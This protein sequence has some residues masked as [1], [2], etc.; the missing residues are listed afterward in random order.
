MRVLIVEDEKRI[1]D[2]LK[3]SLEAEYFAVD[4]VDDGDKGAYYAQINDYDLIILDIMLPKKDGFEVLHEL[5]SVGI[6]I[7][8]LVLSVKSETV[9][10]VDFLNAGADDYLTKPFVLSEL[11]A[12][13]R[14]LLRR[15]QKT[16]AE[17]FAV[18]DLTLN[19]KAGKVTRGKRDIYLTRKE[20]MLLRYLMQ[21]EG[22]IISRGMI[23][24]HVWDM[25]AD[26]F[27]NTI[28][29]H[30]LSLRKKLGDTGKTRLIQTVPGRGYKIEAPLT[31]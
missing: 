15:P 25:S 5:R 16:E 11:L 19:V 31:S 29:S 1:A 20:F 24:E 22:S 14:A 26:I 13:I 21:N 27:S 7:P 18:G 9:K 10:K 30:I 6:T 17:V 23:L 12:R 2:F 3:E 28:E 4:V 8:I